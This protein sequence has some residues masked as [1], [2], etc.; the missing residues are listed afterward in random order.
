MFTRLWSLITN[1]TGRQRF[2]GTLSE[3]LHFHLDVYADDLMRK[4]LSR[5]TAYRRA[6]VHFGSVERVR[7]E[8]RQAT[9]LRWLDEVGQDLRYGIRCLRRFP[10]VTAVAALTL[11]LGIGMNSAIFSL[12]DALLLKPLPHHEPDRSRGGL[13]RPRRPGRPLAGRAHH[14]RRPVVADAHRSI[15]GH[16]ILL[17]IAASTGG[18]R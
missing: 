7:D 14:R 2:E 1:L 16:R 8:C 6:R 11:A 3:E 17:G 9:G 18:R 12:V 5:P 10:A 13:A 15:P 4:G